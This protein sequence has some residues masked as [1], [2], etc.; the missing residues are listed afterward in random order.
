LKICV[1]NVESDKKSPYRIRANS[2]QALVRKYDAYA[3]VVDS[4]RQEYNIE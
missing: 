3:A 2:R 4:R 1:C